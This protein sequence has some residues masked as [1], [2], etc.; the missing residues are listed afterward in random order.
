MAYPGSLAEVGRRFVE[1]AA[2]PQLG[3]EVEV[4]VAE[5]G[6]ELDGAAE[7][8]LGVCPECEYHWYVPARQRIAQVFDT[9]TFEEWDAALDP[10]GHARDGLELPESL[11]ETARLDDCA[12][13]FARAG[14]VSSRRDGP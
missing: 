5:L 11:V 7:R 8:R 4:G 1:L 13:S 14:H 2:A 6:I 12:V 9:G 10:E 3:R